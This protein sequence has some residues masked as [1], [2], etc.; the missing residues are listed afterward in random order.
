[1]R[2][3]SAAA[4]RAEREASEAARDAATA[5]ARDARH[6]LFAICRSLDAIAAARLTLDEERREDER[7]GGVE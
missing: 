6:A 1:M 4:A 5:A 3:A 7:G 2:A